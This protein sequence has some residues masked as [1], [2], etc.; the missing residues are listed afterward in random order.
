MNPKGVAANSFGK[1]KALIWS[2]EFGSNRNNFVGLNSILDVSTFLPA[3][4]SFPGVEM[5]V[6]QKNVKHKEVHGTEHS[7]H[8]KGQKRNS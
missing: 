7:N 1:F 8:R 4:L 3:S 2:T 5:A 6:N